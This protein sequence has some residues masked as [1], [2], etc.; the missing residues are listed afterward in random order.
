MRKIFLLFLAIPLFG[1]S[2]DQN[3]VSA[4]RYFPKPD[5]VLEF[6]KAIT[7][8]SQKYHSGDWKWRVFEIQRA[9]TQAV[10]TSLKDQNHGMN[11]INAV[12]LAKNIRRTG[13]KQ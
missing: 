1:M 6:E 13:T 10:S 12:H 4:S 5:K 9:L 7:A 2:Q 8:H 11:L 3:V